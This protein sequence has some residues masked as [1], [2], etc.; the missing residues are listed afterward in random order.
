MIGSIADYR[1]AFFSP[2]LRY[3][4]RRMR[5][6]TLIICIV[7]LASA[8]HA[9]VQVELKFKRLQYVAHEPITA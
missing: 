8:A 2:D 9:H 7:S 5:L 1:R 4:C 3:S 6:L